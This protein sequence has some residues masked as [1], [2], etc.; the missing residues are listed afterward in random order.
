MEEARAFIMD[1]LTKQKDYDF[2]PAGVLEEMVQRLITLDEAFMLQTGVNDGAEYDDDAA[3]TAI[4]EGMSAAF[5]EHKMYMMR[6]TE[7][8][9]DYN[10]EYLESIGAIEWT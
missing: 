6:L 3:L 10:E 8:Y 4:F 7:D 2:L 5:P 9:L 1:C